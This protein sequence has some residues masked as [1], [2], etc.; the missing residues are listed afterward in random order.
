MTGKIAWLVPHPIQGSGG[1]RTI[2][3]HIRNLVERGH[4]CHVYIGEDERQPLE[5]DALREIVERMFG[6]CPAHFYKGYR[7]SGR[8]DLAVATAWWTAEAVVRGVDADHKLYFVQ[9]FEPCFNPM[10]D[11]YIQAENSYRR[12][13]QPIT[14]GRW[15]SHL[16]HERYGADV[17]FFEFTADHSIYYPIEPTTRESA[18]CFVHQ[19]EKPRRCPLIGREAL[20][21]VKHYCPEVNIYTYGSLET[22]D[23]YFDHTHLGILSREECNYLYNRCTVGLCLSSSNPSRIPFEMMAAGLPAVDFYGDNTIFDIPEHAALLAERNPS[24]VAGAIIKILRSPELQE[25]M[26]QHGLDF[27]Q[28]RPA[29]LEFEQFAAR[30]EDILAGRNKPEDTIVPLYQGAPYSADLPIPQPPPVQPP[31]SS[32]EHPPQQT[33][34]YQRLRQNRIGRVLKVMWKGYY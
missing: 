28:Q 13:L 29:R 11:L 32:N 9:D 6:P 33:G 8:F 5:E 26:R 14:I 4:E 15:L 16:L 19:P 10:G 18:V 1:H 3:S 25:R 23:Y 12:G 34:L 27:M 2:F 30:V 20:A 7:V 17:N 24:S 22:P 31:P 21:A